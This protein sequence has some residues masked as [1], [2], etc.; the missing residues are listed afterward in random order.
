MT[1]EDIPL[2]YGRFGARQSVFLVGF[3]KDC[4]L[5]FGKWLYVTVTNVVKLWKLDSH[6]KCSTVF[7]FPGTSFHC[8][9][10][11]YLKLYRVFYI[12]F[13]SH[14]DT[15]FLYYSKVDNNCD[16]DNIAR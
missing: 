11:A 1:R 13:F 4:L 15:S 7:F 12:F 16:L 2:A 6:F 9:P 5:S 14:A 3:L 8:I 10:Q